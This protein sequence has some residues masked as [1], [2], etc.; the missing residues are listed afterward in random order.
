MI[1]KCFETVEG[2]VINTLKGLPNSI[3][4]LI[5]LN[6]DMFVSSCLNGEIKMWKIKN[7]SRNFKCVKTIKAYDNN[8]YIF[9][10]IL[11]EGL[12]I[13]R[14]I[15]SKEFKIWD[16]KTLECVKT[17]MEDGIINYLV[18]NKNNSIVTTT[19]DRKLNLWKI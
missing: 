12:M 8:Q 15:N 7:D 18:V 19:T 5:S 9:I 3:Y 17:Y 1:Y 6:D 14:Q 4:S 10:N 16:V 2:N 13:S 11:T